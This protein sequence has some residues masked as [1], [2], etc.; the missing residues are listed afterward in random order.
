MEVF[1]WWFLFLLC[2]NLVIGSSSYIRRRHEKQIQDLRE[3]SGL[4]RKSTGSRRLKP[5]PSP[6]R[7]SEYGDAVAIA[8]TDSPRSFW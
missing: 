4:S 1:L 8:A 7:I 6:Q 5:T 3:Q 2:V